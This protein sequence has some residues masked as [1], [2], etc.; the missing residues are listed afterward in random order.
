M[1]TYRGVD[2]EDVMHIYD[3]ILPAIKMNEFDSVLV[4]WMNLECVI[5]SEVSQRKTDSILT[6]I[7][8]I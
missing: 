8:G 1:S 5:L 2:K 4:R 7:Y 3:G 6:H